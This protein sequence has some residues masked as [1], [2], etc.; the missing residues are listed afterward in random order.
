MRSLLPVLLVASFVACAQPPPS[1]R[2]AAAGELVQP[3]WAQLACPTAPVEIG[4]DIA[5]TGSVAAGAT[6]TIQ[7]PPAEELH[8]G[9]TASH[10]YTAAGTY[11]VVLTATAPGGEVRAR[12]LALVVDPNAAPGDDDAPP[13]ADDDTPIDDAPVVVDD[14]APVVDDAGDDDA[15]VG[16]PATTGALTARAVQLESY[17]LF[18]FP[19]D[20][21]DEVAEDVFDYAVDL[22]VLSTTVTA[23]LA[24]TG[25]ADGLRGVPGFEGATATF[26][27]WWVEDDLTQN[28]ALFLDGE[29][30]PPA[31]ATKVDVGVSGS[32]VVVV[33]LNGSVAAS[34][35]AEYAF[36]DDERAPALLT[37]H[38]VTGAMDV[39]IMVATDTGPMIWDV[40]FTFRDAAGN[41]LG[42]G[43]L[44]AG[45]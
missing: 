7:F 42:G 45:N 22:T 24:H 15:P 39:R 19:N 6:A 5:V 8:D 16:G 14:N 38:P 10:A 28:V 13:V 3:P 9:T 36:D 31:G 34:A 35:D 37:N 20:W 44:T 25:T 41:D 18:G 27:D 17:A 40:A 23:E 26:D 21:G 32:D 1:A 30:T 33:S 12:C 4:V 43:T 2:E 29:L 11:T